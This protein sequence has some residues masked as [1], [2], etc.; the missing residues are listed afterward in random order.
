MITYLNFSQIILSET[1]KKAL[2]FFYK[3]SKIQLA[4]SRSYRDVQKRM[5]TPTRTATIPN[6]LAFISQA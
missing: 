1:I 6:P 5:P 3:R 4:D 2:I